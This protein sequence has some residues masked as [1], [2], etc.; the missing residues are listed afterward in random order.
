MAPASPQSKREPIR[1]V[2]TETA[3]AGNDSKSG[4][5]GFVLARLYLRVGDGVGG[6]GE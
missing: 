2:G 1:S 6:S 3:P 4:R 5:F